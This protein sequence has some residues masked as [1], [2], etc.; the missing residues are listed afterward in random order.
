MSDKAEEGAKSNKE[1][2]SNPAK[3]SRLLA[4]PLAATGDATETETKKSE[5]GFVGDPTGDVTTGDVTVGTTSGAGNAAKGSFPIV[6]FA[7]P[8]LFASWFRFGKRNARTA[9][10]VMPSFF[11]IPATFADSSADSSRISLAA[12]AAAAGRSPPNAST[13]TIEFPPRGTYLEPGMKHVPVTSASVAS[14]RPATSARCVTFHLAGS[15]P[16][17]VRSELNLCSPR[18]KWSNVWTC[19]ASSG[20]EN[21]NWEANAP[22]ASAFVSHAL[23]ISKSAQ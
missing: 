23:R 14:C 12:T 2:L 4:F 22:S 21:A 10:L 15:S 20:Y 6:C 3:T 1:E 8:I 17:R 5:S 16:F 9:E 19:R 18:Y 13:N 11:F 7:I